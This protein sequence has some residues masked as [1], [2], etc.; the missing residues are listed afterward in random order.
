[1]TQV[2]NFTEMKIHSYLFYSLF[3][4][5]IS[6]NVSA[7]DTINDCLK[8]KH[9]ID[10]MIKSI[11]INN[12]EK[13]IENLDCLI[14][15]STSCLKKSEVQ[16]IYL[17]ILDQVND[18]KKQSEII[19]TLKRKAILNGYHFFMVLEDLPAI[20]LKDNFNLKYQELEHLADSMFLVKNKNINIEL[21]FVLRHMVRRDQAIRT[22][23]TQAYIRKDTLASDSLM[24][25]MRNV[26]FINEKLLG[27]IFERYGYPGYSLVGSE[28]NACSLLMHH[29]PLEFQFKYIHLLIK[30]VEN[31]ELF[32]N[33]NFLI[34]KIL[35]NKYKITLYGTHWSNNIPELDQAIIS[36]YLSIL[37]NQ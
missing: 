13:A 27:E 3:F 12:I 9:E 18:F 11:N 20:Y 29:M 17:Q 30:A 1:M 21:A 32:E 6:N 36:K 34:D 19:Y 4:F 10:S 15:T 22:R 16:Q 23:E 8:Q 25:I 7:N 2:L 35:Y 14:F 26:D 5:A 24:A 37:N 33:L 31:K 28:H